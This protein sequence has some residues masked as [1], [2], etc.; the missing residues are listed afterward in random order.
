[1]RLKYRNYN[2]TCGRQGNIIN[3]FHIIR[4]CSRH[5]FWSAVRVT[6]GCFP[7]LLGASVC[8][9]V[10]ALLRSSGVHL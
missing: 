10:V 7:V 6:F 5:S 9:G 3:F 1:M 2:K 4:Y 8:V